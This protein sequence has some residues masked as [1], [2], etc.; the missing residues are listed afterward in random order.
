M[1]EALIHAFSGPGAGFMYAITAVM[2]LGLAIAVERVWLFWVRWT[3]DEDAV[4]EHL[5]EK[6]LDAALSLTEGH[7]VSGL[8]RAGQ[9]AKSG[10]DSW[11]RMGAKAALVESMIRRR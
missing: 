1:I 10:E 3:M 9:A 6:N 5:E 7:P 8:I 4:L 2:A 11:D